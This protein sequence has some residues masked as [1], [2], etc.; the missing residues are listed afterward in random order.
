LKA[1]QKE[2]IWFE[3]SGHNPWVDESGL[4]M[5]VIVNNILPATIQ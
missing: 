1:P 3:H 4:F 5:D 2:I